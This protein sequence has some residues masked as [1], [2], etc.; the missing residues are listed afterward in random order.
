MDGLKIDGVVVAEYAKT[1]ESAAGELESAAADVSG[2]PVTAESYG[3]LGELV[4]LGPS[5]SRAAGAL[6]RQLTE[7]AAA[8]RSAA[9]ALGKVTARHADQDAE[10]ADLI[11]R[12]GE[13]TS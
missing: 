8:L 7:G 1:V 11:R 4:G 6:R 5:Y 2:E 13:L 10:S 9:D 12:A 3:A